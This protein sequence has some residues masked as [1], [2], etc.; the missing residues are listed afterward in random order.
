MYSIAYKWRLSTTKYAYITS[1]QYKIDG[2]D[3]DYTL[4]QIPA[5][6]K[7]DDATEQ[8][9]KDIVRDMSAD[10]YRQCFDYMYELIQAD[11]DGQYIKLKNWEFYYHFK[12]DENDDEKVLFVD[13]TASAKT[14]Y[15]DEAHATVFNDRGTLKFTFEIP[16]GIDGKNGVDGKDGVDGAPIN[17]GIYVESIYK[18][19]EKQ[20]APT[21]KIPDDW[22]VSGSTYQANNFRPNGWTDRPTGISSIYKFEWI[23]TRKYDIFNGLWGEFSIPVLTARWGEDGKDGDGIEYIYRGTEEYITPE[24]IIP[25]DNINSELYQSNGFIP[26]GWSDT[27]ETINNMGRKYGWISMRK[28]IDGIWQP[29]SQPALWSNWADD[30]DGVEYIYFLTN[31]NALPEFDEYDVNTNEYQKSDY[32]PTTNGKE[33]NDEYIEPN[34]L[35]RYSWVS[36]RKQRNGKW[37]SFSEPKIW[38]TFKIGGKTT[39]DLYARSDTKL[40]SQDLPNYNGN[41]YYSFNAGGFFKDSGLTE[42]II[43]INSINKNVVWVHDIPENT[44]KKYLYKTIANIEIIDNYDEVIAV[45]E[46]KWYGPYLLSSNGENGINVAPYVTLDDDTLSLPIS[47]TDNTPHNTYAYS[48]NATLYYSDSLVKITNGNATVSNNNDNIT[49][50][51]NE[52]GIKNEGNSYHISFTIN[53]EKEFAE[54]KF[55]SVILKGEH[56][57]NEI[58]A[59]AQFKIIPFYTEDTKLYQ[60]VL[61]KNTIFVPQDLCVTNDG[62]PWEEKLNVSVIDDKGDKSVVGYLCYENKNSELVDFTIDN[63]G[64]NGVLNFI[65]CPDLIT[66]EEY[67][68]YLLISELPNPLKIVHLVDDK[69][70]EIEYVD[71]VN[72][73]RDGIDGKDGEPGKDGANGISSKIV[74]VYSVTNENAKPD[75]PTGGSFNFETNE[76]VYPNGWGEY[77]SEENGV[78]WY[79]QTVFYSDNTENAKWIDPIRLTGE[80]GKDGSSNILDLSNDMDQIYTSDNEVIADQ[81]IE[82][83]IILTNAEISPDDVKVYMGETEVIENITKTK[84]GTGVK[85]SLFFAKGTKIEK[86]EL[87]YI[88]KVSSVTYSK[89][90]KII[91]INGAIDYDLEATPTFIKIDNEGNFSPSQLTVK[92]KKSDINVN[93]REITELS[94]IPAGF[95]LKRYVDN[96]EEYKTIT[97]LTTIYLNNMVP[98][99]EKFIK[100]D[101]VNGDNV[102]DSIIIECVSDGQNGEQGPQGPEGETG[103]DGQNGKL[104]YPMGEWKLG[105][106]YTSTDVI[107]PFVMFGGEY[108]VLIA[109]ESNPEIAPANEDGTTTDGWVKMEQYEAIYTKLLVADNGLIGGSV[110]NGDYVFS[111]NGVIDGNNTNEY[112]LFNDSCVEAIFE[113]KVTCEE[114]ETESGIELTCLIEEAEGFIPNYLVDFDKG[115]AWFGGGNTRIDENGTVYTKDIVN[116]FEEIRLPIP[117]ESGLYG[118]YTWDVNQVDLTSPDYNKK[119]EDCYIKIIEHLDSF[120]FDDYQVCTLQNQIL[121]LLL[122]DDIIKN[123]NVWYKGVIYLIKDCSDKILDLTHYYTQKGGEKKYHNYYHIYNYG[124]TKIEFMFKWDGGEN[125]KRYNNKHTGAPIYE[126]KYKTGELV[127]LDN[128]T[129]FAWE[130]ING[131]TGAAMTALIEES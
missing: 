27:P 102:Y 87:L 111:K 43:S 40:I 70:R 10:E 68:D 52:T 95:E 4:A 65:S 42:E 60:I 129:E 82:T 5:T 91:K 33:W 41:I 39:I 114:I 118:D 28:E 79:S 126:K 84:D 121:C 1:T 37:L 90:F 94:E 47:R 117:N 2:S 26:E 53:T 127:L 54:I 48:F 6:G 110:Y 93:N 58:E 8:I 85:I 123:K 83:T 81:T 99:P 76:I 34:N 25:D 51:T 22:D 21:V 105:V 106:T 71:F 96:L 18:L 49:I 19:T 97:S 7:L 100:F 109:N 131:G 55:I 61:D 104:L 128:L 92:I 88:I 30:G 113:P 17:D 59:V 12:V 20:I 78:V 77:N 38:N 46:E 98:K 73:P 50:N 107:T 72:I 13:A 64:I 120:V 101:L 9:I 69:I 44:E 57:G 62:K 24:I 74:A 66:S 112:S 108:Y 130:N 23:S 45:S 56:N 103:N 80:K 31:S 36:S 75:T 116:I 16:R 35:N 124:A 115:R 11:E 122:P 63:D 3:P 14:S 125:I 32:L 29:F 15:D 86:N 89:V 119:L 67:N